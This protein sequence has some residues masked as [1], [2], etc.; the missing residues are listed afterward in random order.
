MN[1]IFY[2]KLAKTNINK[3]RKIYF[4]YILAIIAIVMTFY[5]MKAI[6]INEGIDMMRCGI[7]VKML[8]K[9]ATTI[10][11]IFAVIFLFYTNSFII[12]N[13]KKEIGLYN[14]LGMEKKHIAKVFFF[15]TVIVVTISIVLGLLGGFIIGKL[16]FLI[17]LNLA[18]FD[19]TLSFSISFK[20]II[21]TIKLI[22]VTFIAILIMNLIQIKVTNPV[23]LLKSG[24]KGERMPKTSWFSAILGVVFLIIGYEI[25]LAVESPLAAINKFFIATIFVIVGTYF[26]FKA[27]IITLLKILKKNKKFYYST[28]N[29]ISVSSMIY[30]MKQNAA[31]LANICILSTAVL[32][33]ISTTVCLYMGE[34]S[35]LKNSYPQDIQIT[36]GDYKGDKN[37]VEDAVNSELNLNN[38]VKEN[39]IEFDYKEFIATLDNNRFNVVEKENIMSN[40]SSV[41]GVAF[42]TLDKYKKVEN[43]NVKLN[44]NEIFIYTNEGK[45]EKDTVKLGNSS[46][47][48]KEELTSL[49]FVNKE[50]SVN[51]KSYFIVVKD[52]EI[53]NEIGKSLNTEELNKDKYY[54]SFDIKGS[55]EDCINFCNNTYNK[56][57]SDNISFQSIFM[58]RE[59]Y[60]AMNGGFLFIGAYLGILFTMAMVLIIYYKQ[61]SE[62]YEDNERFK[63]MKKVGISDYEVK[64]SI[65]KQILLVFFI[66]LVT[67]I[68]H[69]GFA[70]KMMNK[71]LALFGVGSTEIFIQCIFGT[72]V[73]FA[74]IYIVVYRLTARTYYK[75][76]NN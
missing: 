43:T 21:S 53:L 17:L 50:D 9:F 16:M 4:P 35:S 58:D 42:I 8:L 44:E 67:A 22:L 76:V 48:V 7:Q 54:I 47:K 37:T 28:N 30:R 11:G 75:I 68:I 1:S 71:M 3:N 32:L 23:E 45:Y 14:I 52:E 29:F 73:V 20:A 64:K 34:E 13:R 25:A 66:P 33:T 65:K 41:C 51:I 55:K 15:E 31:G 56:I 10:I 27:G 49:K 2:F 70:F 40:I 38:L 36:F 46:Y 69:V 62:G 57:N 5:T 74:I 61:I 59:A 19:I 6:S 72:S 63:I 39:T 24:Q 18:K 60:Y 12:K 26:T